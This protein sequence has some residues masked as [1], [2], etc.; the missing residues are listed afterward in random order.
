MSDGELVGKFPV[1]EAAVARS[2]PIHDAFEVLSDAAMTPS[3]LGS[4]AMRAWNKGGALPPRG[5]VRVM[6][7]TID[8]TE[9][10]HSSNIAFETVSQGSVGTSQLIGKSPY[11][12]Q[13]S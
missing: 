2:G 12:R 10:S 3:P 11:P 8:P 7:D 9:P 5:N 1:N 6:I 13:R 4:R